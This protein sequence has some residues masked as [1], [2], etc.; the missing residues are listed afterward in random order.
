MAD[1]S[2]EWT[3]VK[4]KTKYGRKPVTNSQSYVN[5]QLQ[6]IGSG[7]QSRNI[8]QSIMDSHLKYHSSKDTNR[9]SFDASFME[10]VNILAE[11]LCRSHYVATMIKETKDIIVANCRYSEEHQR[12]NKELN[13]VVLGIGNYLGSYSSF[14][15]LVM[16]VVLSRALSST[17]TP[18]CVSIF[19]PL[20]TIEECRLCRDILSFTMEM[21]NKRGKV[22]AS[23]T[24]I[25]TM[26][27]MPH[28]PYQIYNNILWANWHN[29][30]RI[31]IIGN[32]YVDY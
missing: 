15:Q 11:S 16:V 8:M 5:V 29:L 13:I 25:V 3:V 18:I 9:N 20:L 32:R 1:D 17:A 4:T 2:D 23:S 22:V 12:C 28:C 6:G 14:I 26:F 21:E 24:S 30:D 10:L 31:L 19:D 7:M 27:Y